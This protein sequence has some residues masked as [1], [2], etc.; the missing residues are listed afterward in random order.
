MWSRRLFLFWLLRYC[1]RAEKRSIFLTTF[2]NH[3]VLDIFGMDVN[4]VFAFT[5]A[6]GHKSLAKSLLV[7]SNLLDYY[8]LPFETSTYS[9][10]DQKSKIYVL[11][12]ILSSQHRSKKN[13]NSDKKVTHCS[14]VLQSTFCNL[15]PP[16]LSLDAFQKRMSRALLEQRAPSF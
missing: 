6:L 12:I 16:S 2:Q 11:V 1:E 14:S 10:L 3:I 9:K 5:F 8:Y 7:K 4:L 15:Y 13:D